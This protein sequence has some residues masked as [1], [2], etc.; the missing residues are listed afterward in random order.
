MMAFL[1]VEVV[2]QL[3]GDDDGERAGAICK[4]ARAYYCT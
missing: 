1:D 4:G 3:F 2:T